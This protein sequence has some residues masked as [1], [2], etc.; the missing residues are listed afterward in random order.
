M[1]TRRTVLAA[2]LGATLPARAAPAAPQLRRGISL[3]PWFS[4]TKEYPAPRTDYAWPPFQDQRPVP[5]RAD[6]RRLR[7]AGFDFVRIPVDP[8]PFLAFD[9]TLFRR[10]LLDELDDA[11]GLCLAVGLDVVVNVQINEATHHWNSRRLIADRQ[12]PDLAAYR[13][14]VAE[15]AR[16]L[17]PARTVL[18]PVNEPPQACGSTEW[19]A[20]QR[21]LLAAAR[22]AAP[23]L[24]LTATGACGSMVPGLQALDPKPLAGLGPLT[25][26]VHFY[27]PYLFT[28]QGAPWMR[29]EP[30]Y[31]A[32]NAV[33]WPASAGTLDATL[34]AVRRRMAQ[35]TERSGSEKAAAVAETEAKMREYFDARPD[36]NFLVHGLSGV[37]DWARTNGIAPEKILIGE[38][39]A[40]RSDARYVAAGAADRARYIRDL[41]ETIEGYGF[42]WAYWNFFDGFG[43]VTDDATRAFDP[44]VV[45]ALGMRMPG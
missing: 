34:A 22:A 33:P 43:L 12:A 25:Y 44:A 39:G 37:R 24:T 18:E 16:R 28:H 26:V 29:G 42:G 10:R 7:E 20:I 32:L 4:L 35:D 14:L 30:I 3:W 9:G 6:L 40:L 15:I 21:D 27:E 13:A 41:R 45:A 23:T 5:K 38:F 19:T 36:R 2:A 11:V 1:P 31:R 8:G 17:D